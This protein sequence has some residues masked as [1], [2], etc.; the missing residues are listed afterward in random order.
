MKYLYTSIDLAVYFL[1]SDFPVSEEKRILQ[2]LW[3]QRNS[4]LLPKYRTNKK[5][6][7]DSIYK[8]LSE[9]DCT[10]HELDE[11]NILMQDIDYS[12]NN[13]EL[14][15]QGIIESFFK[16]IKLE[17]T[18]T[19]NK[20]YRK[21][22]LRTLIARFGYKRRS[23]NLI[24]YIDEALKSLGLAIFLRGHVPCSIEE[25]NL[26]DTIIIRLENN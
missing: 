26:D 15:E 21:I 12:S 2:S 18:Y 23:A 1:I 3:E 6:F 19:P 20:A 11:L 24:G 13:E 25:I 10:L 14:N 17:L 16:I 8:D 7:R 4:V 9:Y 5:F 22:K